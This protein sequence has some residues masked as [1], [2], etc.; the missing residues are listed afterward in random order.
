M[1]VPWRANQHAI[2]R[3]PHLAAASACYR[4]FFCWEQLSG[5]L[6]YLLDVRKKAILELVSVAAEHVAGG[7]LL[8]QDAG[9]DGDFAVTQVYRLYLP[10]PHIDEHAFSSNTRNPHLSCLTMFKALHSQSMAQRGL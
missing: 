4:A 1:I 8:F 10:S 7:G 5:R 6:L 2:L 9:A 3:R